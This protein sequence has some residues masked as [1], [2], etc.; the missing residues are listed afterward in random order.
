AW[1]IRFKSCRPLPAEAGAAAELPPAL[2][3]REKGVR[4]PGSR[5]L[6]APL[7][8]FFQGHGAVPLLVAG[9]VDERDGPL[10]GDV[11][12]QRQQVALA[13]QFGPIPLAELR[14]PGWVVAVPLAQFGAGGEAFQPEVD[15][16]LLLAHATRPQPLHQDPQAVVLRRRCVSPLEL[17]HAWP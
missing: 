4:H 8:H 10:L 1:T 11:L 3:R 7:Q 9:G 13:F 17:Y 2:R 6:L 15:L 5:S 12:Q 14:P 16:R